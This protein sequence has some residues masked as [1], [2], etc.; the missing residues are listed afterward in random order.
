[1]ENNIENNIKNNNNIGNNIKNNIKDNIEN[2]IKTEVVE[3]KE[4]ELITQE[5]EVFILN[6]LKTITP[7]L[8]I[9]LKKKN[10]KIKNVEFSEKGLTIYVNGDKNVVYLIKPDQ[11]NRI[12]KK[13][14][15][16]IK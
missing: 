15:E 16:N 12:L 9:S 2:N 13:A 4:I 3:V 6:L 14:F 5:T 7:F 10:N 1:M 11:L 8:A